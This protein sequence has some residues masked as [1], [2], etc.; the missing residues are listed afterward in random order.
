MFASRRDGHWRVHAFAAS[1]P[2]HRRADSRGALTTYES[3]RPVAIKSR[4]AHSQ[5]RSGIART[6][7]IGL[8]STCRNQPER[9]RVGPTQPSRLLPQRSLTASVHAGHHGLV[10]RLRSRQSGG[11]R[12]MPARRRAGGCS[13]RTRSP[14]AARPRRLSSGADTRGV[15]DVSARS[16]SGGALRLCRQPRVL[17]PGS[18]GRTGALR[19]SGAPGQAALNEASRGTSHFSATAS[20]ETMRTRRGSRAAARRRRGPRP[21]CAAPP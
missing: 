21:G 16:G 8:R 7:D 3:R 15:G 10:E 2:C 1:L 20:T 4:Y 17:A 11:R 18:A 19:E 13:T 12:A 6:E 9:R 5:Q 14:R